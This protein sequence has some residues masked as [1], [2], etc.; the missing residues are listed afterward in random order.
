M[1]TLDHIFSVIS[2]LDTC[3]RDSDQM[4]GSTW[5]TGAWCGSR[6]PPRPGAPWRSVL[7]FWCSL[8]QRESSLETII[9]W[10]SRYS[11]LLGSYP[12]RLGCPL[13]RGNTARH[14]SCGRIC[15]GSIFPRH[16]IYKP[17]FPHHSG[18][19]NTWRWPPLVSYTFQLF[20]RYPMFW[21]CQTD[22]ILKDMWK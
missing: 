3:T 1:T 7:L 20:I 21:F 9:E 16:K 19:W 12:G 22:R 14:C 5:D 17:R 11:V 15:V 18:R 13:W 6:D 2:T 4:F 10:S 8:W